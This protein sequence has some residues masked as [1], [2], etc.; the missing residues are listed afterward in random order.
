MTEDKRKDKVQRA[1]TNWNPKS[2]TMPL[3]SLL[4]WLKLVVI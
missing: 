3:V 2:H 4:L 1:H